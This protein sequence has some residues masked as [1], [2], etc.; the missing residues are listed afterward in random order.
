MTRAVPIIATFA[1]LFAPQAT[2]GNEFVW[3]NR[4]HIIGRL[5]VP[6]GFAIET[7]DYRE[8]T[9]TTL[10]YA[11]GA[12]IV[13]QSGGMYRVPMFQDSDHKLTSSK[14]LATKTIRVGQIGSERCWREDNFKP[15]KVT[16]KSVSL[17]VLF[18]PNV[19]Y[20]RVPRVRRGE[21]DRALDSFVREIDQAP[22]QG[23]RRIRGSM[24]QQAYLVSRVEPVYPVVAQK[25]RDSG[26]GLAG[27]RYWKGWACGE[28][29][30]HQRPSGPGRCRRGCGAAMGLQPH[31]PN[32]RRNP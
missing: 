30:A 17:A 5:T 11:D 22:H 12:T 2:P 21:F 20:T 3:Q 25:E 13:L 29:S 19:G 14:E 1:A 8:G 28:R 10:R 6:T 23:A 7:D 15:R 26:R 24:I 18:P 9:V 31:H 32:E 27:S 4:D 16:G